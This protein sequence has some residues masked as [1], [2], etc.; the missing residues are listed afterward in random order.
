MGAALLAAEARECFIQFDTAHLAGEMIEILITDNVRKV[1]I[2]WLKVN[3]PETNNKVI[4]Q[5]R[6]K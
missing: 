2:F 4:E 5:R 1:C 3:V 6:L